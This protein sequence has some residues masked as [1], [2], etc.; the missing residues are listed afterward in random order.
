MATLRQFGS[1][2][3]SI[4]RHDSGT[5]AITF[6]LSIVPIL[7]AGGAAI[8]YMRY[9]NAETR[10]QAAL[11]S[12]ALAAAVA[13]DLSNDD[14][15]DAG[16]S[17][18]DANLLTGGID[19]DMVEADIK[20]TDKTVRA[21]AHMVLPSGLMQIA[22]LSAFSVDVATEIRVPKAKSA[23]IALVLDYSLSMADESGGQVK[24]VAMKN[25][26]EKLITD[27]ETANPHK[28][29]IG[30]VPFSHHVYVTLPAKYVVGKGTVG[31]WTGCTQDR[32]YPYNLT[33]G[34]PTSDDATKWGQPIAK[35]HASDGCDFYAP[36]QLKVAPLSNN[37]DALRSQLEAMRPYAWTHIALGAEFG[38]HLLS[39]DAPFTEGA[40]YGD[41]KVSKIMVI[42][43]D[44][45]QTE[46]AFGPS[47]RSI[48][49]GESNLEDICQNA[50]D[51]GITMITVAFD[52][53]H[54]DTKKRLK[55]CASDPDKDFFVAEDGD[56]LASAFED[57]RK[58]VTAQVFISR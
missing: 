25:A 18:F 43:T 20:V 4:V 57:I 44:G 3:R 24:Y 26:A 27:L 19:P 42:L 8:D 7:L 34:P 38:Y 5:T 2:I 46:P 9:A 23:E 55:D 16:Q 32:R 50:K 45:R 39:P 56:E 37:F 49:Q 47:S 31:D 53:Q 54:V 41:D 29:K 21:T 14:R 35:T 58:Q 52:L 40:P 12:G 33:D 13:T 10:L 15:V 30:L 1:M 11:D 48:S 36:N 17:A 51:S 28:V 22:G 6:A